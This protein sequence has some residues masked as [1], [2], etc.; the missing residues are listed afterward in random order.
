[1]QKKDLTEKKVLVFGTGISGIGAAK[2]L[3]KVQ[4]EVI[5]YDGNEKLC[6][7]EI[8]KK[9]PKDSKC[10][11]VLG[12]L[13]KELLESLDLVVMSPGVPLDIPTVEQIKAAGIPVWGEIELAYQMSAGTV[14]AITGTN[15][16][17]TT[18]A[19]LGEIMK[20]YADS[21]FVVGNIGNPYTD[22]ALSMTEDSYTVAEI[23]SFQLETID[24][25]APKVS[26][27][28]NITEDHLNRHHTMEEYIRVKELITANQ[29]KEDYFIFII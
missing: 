23:S 26:A 3:E 7:E 22:A 6:K 28:L 13:S 15:G 14:L 11:I 1:M 21:V 4:A 12:A 24:T 8:R 5:L 29:T 9:L 10:E 27:I 25:F 19:L 2:L 20:A 17:T 18:T 16:K